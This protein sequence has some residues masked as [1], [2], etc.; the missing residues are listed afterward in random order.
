MRGPEMLADIEN[1]LNEC[2]ENVNRA[3]TRP[4]SPIITLGSMLRC[5]TLS[6]KSAQMEPD[7]CYI[8]LLVSPAALLHCAV[9][10]D[11]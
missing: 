7:E 11:V 3:L 5:S 8:R 4:A 10:S 9:G 6:L 2:N 1:R